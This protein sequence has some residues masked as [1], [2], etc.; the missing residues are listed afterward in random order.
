MSVRLSDIPVMGKL[1][2]A[3][4]VLV[5][6]VVVSGLGITSFLNRTHGAVDLNAQSHQ[7]LDRVSVLRIAVQQQESSLRGFLVTGD[8]GFL[9]AMAPARVS[10]DRAMTEAIAL[11]ADQPS[12]QALLRTVGTVAAEWR[13]QVADREIALAQQPGGLQAAREM[14]AQHV[15]APIMEKLRKAL[16]AAETDERAQLQERSLIADEGWSGMFAMLWSVNAALTVVAV[17]CAFVLARTILITLNRVSTAIATLSEGKVTQALSWT[18]RDEIGRLATAFDRLRA[19]VTQAFAQAQMIAD[20]PLG[21]MTCDP[22]DDFRITYMNKRSEEVLKTVEHLLPCKVDEMLGKSIDILHKHPE[23]Q[24]RL[25]SNPANLPHR[26]KIKLGGE[27]MDLRVTA[28][29]DSEDRYVGPM[30]TWSLVTRQVNLTNDFETNVKG[31]VDLV[32]QAAEEMAR[33]ADALSATASNASGR[34]TAVAAAAEEASANV[35]AVA[36][37]TE[38]LAASIQEIGRQAEASNTRTSQAVDEATQADHLM[39]QLAESAQE[40][41]EVVELITAIASQTN[42]L[43]LNATIEAARAGEAGK[44]F[45]VVAGEVKGLASQ[46]ARATDRIRMKVEEIQ[47][48]SGRAGNALRGMTDLIRDLHTTAAAISAAVE[49]QQAAT[50]EI[51]SNIAQAAQGTRDVTEN[52]GGV[53]HATGE[54]GAAAAQVRGSAA[55]LSKGAGNLSVQVERFL[56]EARA[57]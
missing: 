52:I 6:V 18:R 7:V 29:R 35:A 49:Q 1:N 13:S 26:T 32:T 16:E 37:A 8:P 3:F 10:F 34:S 4:A 39:R 9:D 24:R 41:G 44:G 21:V 27:V 51:A 48:A 43:A 36:S 22:N 45:A 14:V 53:E 2:L 25:L 19:T 42:L 46:T 54:T 15:S 50:S 31:V 57:A 55:E 5:T 40:V 11:T 47:A 12:T 28:I 20:A 23:H 17:I 30:L 56:V 38:Q 33:A